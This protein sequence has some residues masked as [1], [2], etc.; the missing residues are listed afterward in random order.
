MFDQTVL[1]ILSLAP[2]LAYVAG[3]LVVTVYERAQ[4]DQALSTGAANTLGRN[5]D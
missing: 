3:A 5:A 2:V 1:L 4:Q